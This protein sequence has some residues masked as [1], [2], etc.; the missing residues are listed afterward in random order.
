MKNSIL[1][2]MVLGMASVAQA[3]GFICEAQDSGLS[4]K[5]F[6]KTQPTDGTRVAAVMVISDPAINTPNKTIVKFSS[7]N[8][9]LE[10]QGYGKFEAQVDLRYNDSARKGENIAGTKLGQ[11]KTI[12]LDLRFAYTTDSTILAAIANEVPGRITYN[13]RN[14]EVRSEKVSCSRYLKN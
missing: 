5:I 1:A 4:I 14:G 7:E 9:N 3:D 11:L 12:V 10:Y 2:V 8:E 6:N 13:K